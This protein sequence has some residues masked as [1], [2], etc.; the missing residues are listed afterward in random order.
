M[1]APLPDA[2]AAAPPAGST[3]LAA[4][5]SAVRARTEALV[6]P[7]SAEDCQLQSMPDASPSKW[8]LAH[9]TWFFETFLLERHE[10][11]FAPFDPA[12]RVLF[13]SY[14]QGVG[15]QH[16]RAQRGLVS[17][18]TLDDVRAWRRQVDERMT[19][20]IARCA[21]GAEFDA[22]LRLG[23]NHEQ[24]HQELLLT[25]IQHAL[26]CNPARPAY[27]PLPP[28]PARP[29]AQPAAL[30]WFGVPAGIVALGHDVRSDGEFHFDN[31]APCHDLLLRDFELASRPVS[32]GDMRAFIADGGY[33]RPELWLSLGWDWV[34]SGQRRAPLY[35][36]EGGDARFGLHGTQ[37]IDD[38]APAAHLSYFEADAYARWAGARLPSEA[39]WE[40]ASRHFGLQAGNG[41]FADRGLYQPAAA[42]SA[43]HDAP[44]QMFGTVWEWTQ[45]A[46]AA[47]PG[48]RPAAGAVGE[49]NGKF[50]CNQF[51][52]RGG[53]CATPA[54]H[55]RASYRNFFA[56]EAQ[57]QFSGARLARDL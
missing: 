45:S 47:Y 30:Q 20:L 42:E 19:M 36:L 40:H 29:S 57:W 5:Y 56:P 21:A 41:H 32:C 33:R 35:W 55:V 53:S 49:Y 3:D 25:D 10:P 6:A 27:A 26:S 15:P 7:L 48:Y 46:Y 43:A 44:L 17:R 9:T 54:G 51:V 4:A 1:N 18:P 52:L 12:F 39:E 23:M 24:Q 13:N 37:A 22:L 28:P 34:Q 50:M 38:A 11:G 2:V 16:P 14:Y 31:E 8:H